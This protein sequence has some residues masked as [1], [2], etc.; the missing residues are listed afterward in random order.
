M[1][2]GFTLV[3]LLAIVIIL[4]I[5]SV[6]VFLIVG[7]V[8]EDARKSINL[9]QS[10][11]VVNGAESLYASTFL[12]EDGYNPDLESMFNGVTDIYEYI[13]TSGDKPE[14]GM[15]MINDDGKV[16]I[17]INID[18]YCYT[19]RYDESKINV[20]MINEDVKCYINDEG[21]P[22][23]EFSYEQLDFLESNGN[24]YID[25]GLMNTGNYLIEDEVYLKTDN[26]LHMSWLFGGRTDYSYGYGVLVQKLSNGVMEVFALHG[27]SSVPIRLANSVFDKWIKVSFSKDSFVIDGNSYGTSGGIIVPD[28]YE[29]EIRLGGMSQTMSND[30]RNFEGYRRQTVI[31]DLDSGLVVRNFIPVKIRET[32]EL[33]Y[34]DLVNNQFYPNEGEGEFK[35]P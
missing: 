7:D 11:L 20:T 10:Y 31:T 17:A 8:I 5:I 35:A 15:A 21:I 27:G 22:T 16:A 25:I 24:Q 18:N 3:E 32:G 30:T 14:E 6:S 33:G 1:S 26:D 28:S 4:G 29:Q 13:E 23:I 2:R 9:S 34:W 19:K 12:K